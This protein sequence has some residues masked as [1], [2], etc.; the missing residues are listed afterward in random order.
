[1]LI[2]VVQ[3]YTRYICQSMKIFRKYI[4]SYTD[5]PNDEWNIIERAFERKVFQK[6]ELIL[7]QGSV[8]NH[9]YFLEKGLVRFF[10]WKEGADVTKFFTMAPYCFTSS[11]S[12]RNR[13]PALENIQAIEETIVWQ[14]TLAKADELLELQHWNVFT[15]RFLLE[16]QQHTD[17]L[18]MESKTDTA[19]ER[20]RRLMERYP[21]V[22]NKIPVRHLASFLGI[23]PQSLSRI[24]RK[25]V[26]GS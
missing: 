18:L 13:R 14:V 5:L 10:V 4:E 20:Y 19:G 26:W 24:R 17:D 25:M 15:R 2:L 3:F 6:N 7:T 21:S 12:F 8:C 9:F 23:E 11:C 1:M 16:V 22:I